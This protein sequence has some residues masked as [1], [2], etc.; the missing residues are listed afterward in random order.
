MGIKSRCSKEDL[1]SGATFNVRG[2]TNHVKQEALSKDIDKYKID[3]RCLQETKIT[4]HFDKTAPHGNR[5]ITIPSNSQHYG[6]GFIL[7]KK[8]KN[9]V[10]A[11][12]GISDRVLCT[13]T[14]NRQIKKQDKNKKSDKNLMAHIITIINVYGPTT[15]RAT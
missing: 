3:I 1:F 12:W 11:Y 7:N 8:W 2:L 13:T 10:H 4:E 5:L 9:S 14:K 15:E 6:N